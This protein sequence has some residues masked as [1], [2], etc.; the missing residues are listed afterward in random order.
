M[1]TGYTAAIK[2][3]ASF[4]QF[5][6][7]CARG[8]GALIM[9]RDMP[10]DAPIPERFEPQTAYHDAALS[11]ARNQSAWLRQI[12]AA[13]AER[14]AARDYEAQA[15]QQAAQLQASIDLRAQYKAILMQVHAWTPPTHEH[16]G[17]HAFMVEQ[18]TTSI[19]HDCNEDYYRAHPVTQ[20]AGAEWV[21]DKIATY[22]KDIAYHTEARA[23]EIKRT[24]DRNNWLHA[25]R[26]SIT[27]TP[28]PGKE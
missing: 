10:V 16:V 2:D 21:A 9:M 12:S 3:G 22:E 19:N 26:A 24:E 18:L 6:W 5:F 8:M 4:E 14:E 20:K 23:S 1:P 7:R 25:L 27:T 15:A 17:M 11:K 28:A 13:E